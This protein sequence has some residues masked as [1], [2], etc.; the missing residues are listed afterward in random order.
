MTVQPEPPEVKYAEFF[1]KSK[2][3]EYHKVQIAEE[4]LLQFPDH[5]GADLCFFAAK[6]AI[7]AC[8]AMKGLGYS[9]KVSVLL[10]LVREHIGEDIAERFKKLFSLY[11]KSEYSPEFLSPEESAQCVSEAKE[12]LRRCY[13]K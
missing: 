4:M 6:H 9:S 11:I 7:Q 10:P 13:R 1:E 5:T 12:I 3:T 2:E 8:L